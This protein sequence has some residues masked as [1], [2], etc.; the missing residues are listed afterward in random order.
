MLREQR[1]PTCAVDAEGTPPNQVDADAGHGSARQPR[2]TI[3]RIRPSHG[4]R[5]LDLAEL[6]RYRELAVLLAW[7]DVQVRYKQTALGVAWALIQP[8]LAM[9]I[10]ALFFGNLIQVPSDGVPY[11]L[12][13]FV[14]LLPWTYFAN[15]TTN[16]SSSLV[17]NTNL[18][19]KVYFPRLVIPLAGVGSALVDLA[20]GFLVLL[21]LLIAFGVV[22]TI[23]LLFIPLLIVLA[24]L[25]ALGVSIWLSALDVQYRDVRYAI[26]FLIQVWLFATPVVYPASVIPEQYRAFY[27]LNPMSG[28]VE[29]FRWALLGRTPP[30]GPLL[31]VSAVMVLLI[32][33]TGLF[34]FRR[35]ERTF[36]DVI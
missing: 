22:P 17:A 7:R 25:T 2:K 19:S 23:N 26:P 34:Y 36:A 13:A 6:W 35:M 12:F 1:A 8:L 27:G 11:A 3:T 33:V 29:G 24:V 9:G 14:G 32:L 28:V 10:F 15:A 5:A 30:P 31:L 21:V 18:I 16:A 4:W 20:I